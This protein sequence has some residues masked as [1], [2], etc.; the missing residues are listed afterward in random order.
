MEAQMETTADP[1]LLAINASDVDQLAWVPVTGCAGVRAKELWR[2]GDFVDTLI[3]YAPGASTPGLH[4]VGADHHIWLVAGAA[5]V[6]GQRLT[7]G[8][9][10][11]VPPGV[12]HPIE[13][14]EAGCTLLQVH[15]PYRT[16]QAR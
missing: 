10:V 14:A 16:D 7:A 13:A 12:A 9:Y 1:T 4:H 15:R 3:D 6:A 11:H 2:R 8:S 5:T